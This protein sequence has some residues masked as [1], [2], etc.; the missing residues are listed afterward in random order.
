[1]MFEV[2]LKRSLPLEK[3]A[4]YILVVFSIYKS[5]DVENPHA[6]DVAIQQA[7]AVIKELFPVAIIPANLM[8]SAP[9]P[10]DKEAFKQLKGAIENDFIKCMIDSAPKNIQE[11]ICKRLQNPMHEGRGKT[12]SE[13]I[14]LFKS[15]LETASNFN[16][17]KTEFDEQIDEYCYQD[18]ENCKIR[19]LASDAGVAILKRICQSYLV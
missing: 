5:H 11:D 16:E 17:L 9:V 6:R 1:M 7:V 18:K 14:N 3:F 10:Q 4:P 13:V 2:N 12:T 19:T 8:I 15:V